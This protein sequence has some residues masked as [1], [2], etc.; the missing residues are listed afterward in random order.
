MPTKLRCAIYTRV[1]TDTQSEIE[2]N[3]CESQKEQILSYVGTQNDLKVVRVYSDAGYTGSNLKRPALQNLLHDATAGSIDCVLV[4]KIDRLT[5]SPRDFYDLMEYFDTYGISFISTTQRFDTSTA[6]GRLIRNIMLDF[7]QFEREMTVE[8]TKDKMYQRVQKGLW[9]GGIAP[10][11]YKREN[12]KLIIDEQE[13]ACVRAV[14]DS[15]IHTGSLARTREVINRTYKTRKGRQFSKS[16]IFGMLRNP[17]YAGKMRYG[18]KIY[19]GEHEPIVMEAQFMKIQTLLK[20]YEPKGETKIARTYLLAGLIHCADCGSVMTPT[21]TKKKKASGK[22]SYIY[23]YRCTKTYQ[24]GWRACSVKSVNAKKIEQFVIE[25]I[26]ELSRNEVLIHETID[27]INLTEKDRTR[28]LTDEHQRVQKDLRETK[29]RIKN[30]VDAIADG[31]GTPVSL[32]E[33]LQELEKSKTELQEQLSKVQMELVNENLIRYDAELVIQSLKDFVGRIEKADEEEKK[34]LLQV[35]IKQ[36]I[37]GKETI[38][39]ELFYL[40]AIDTGMTN[41]TE[42]LPRPDSNQRPDD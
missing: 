15:Y 17:V 32:T 26:K 23:Y 41:R 13:A 33:K 30:I 35:V 25:Q 12:K 9:N 11:G 31:K 10:Y 27:R 18:G 6:T 5:R 42:L 19:D 8:R 1:S 34:N 7:A 2:F 3:S 14:F 39:I 21:Y 40:P 22:P 4:Y 29:S 37:Y 36:I 16:S 28:H 38:R 20:Q 24:Y